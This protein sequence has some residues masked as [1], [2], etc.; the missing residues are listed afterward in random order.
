[1]EQSIIALEMANTALVAA[2][3]VTK[4]SIEARIAAA[5]VVSINNALNPLYILTAN[6]I[7]TQALLINLIN[8]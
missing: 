6:Q 7:T 1:M 3:N 8:K 4:N 2:V 5:V